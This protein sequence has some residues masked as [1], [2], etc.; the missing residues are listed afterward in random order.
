MELPAEIAGHQPEPA[1]QQPAQPAAQPAPAATPQ[2]VPPLPAA[3]AMQ[4]PGQQSPRPA[5][6]AEQTS[7]EPA[8]LLG[9]PNP[10]DAPV[11][12]WGSVDLG[13]ADLDAGLVAGFGEQAVGL[14]LTPKQC[15]SLAAW[16][17]KAVSEAWQAEYKKES[18]ALAKVWVSDLERNRSAVRSLAQRI[19]RVPGLEKFTAELI[20]SGAANNATVLAGLHVLASQLGEDHAGRLAPGPGT[21]S[22]TAL[23][24]I[25]DVAR[26][27]RGII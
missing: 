7:Q 8:S 18:E 11:T 20:R 13:I 5:A 3:A 17:A 22:E 27:S 16:H 4:A 25:L 19:E 2:P 26:R 24:G 23:E 14:G 15:K 1:S 12:D 6:A 10:E 9:S 21:R